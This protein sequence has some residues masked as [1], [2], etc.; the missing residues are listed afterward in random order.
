MTTSP[1]TMGV[2]NIKDY[3]ATGNKTDDAQPAIRR[4][5]D[6]CAAY[7]GGTV[8]IPPGEYTTGTIHLQ[9]R[10][11]IYVESGATIY[12]SKVPDQFRKYKYRRTRDHRRL[13]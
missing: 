3:G 1:Q 5:I 2:F 8:Y 12:S 10:I 9:S 11:R 6:A 7:G 13:G 4:A